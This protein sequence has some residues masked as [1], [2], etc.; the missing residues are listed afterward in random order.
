MRARRELSPDEVD[1]VISAIS[2]TAENLEEEAD[3][4][5]QQPV[6]MTEAANSLKQ[7]VRW[8]ETGGTNA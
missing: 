3:R 8:L 2:M 1:A 6:K 5:A 7:L 4:L